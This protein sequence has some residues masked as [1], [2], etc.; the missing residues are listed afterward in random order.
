MRLDLLDLLDTVLQYDDDG[1][2]ITQSGQ[3]TTSVCVLG[4][5]DRQQDDSHRAGDLGGVGAYRTRH[6]DRI[7]TIGPQFDL[8]SRCAPADQH[9]ITGSV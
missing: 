6:H 4:R 8:R 5:F 3:P 7:G 9:G 1:L 2:L